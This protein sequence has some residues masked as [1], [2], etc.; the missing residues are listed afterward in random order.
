VLVID[1]DQDFQASVRALLESQGYTVIAAE[2]GK[3]GLQMLVEHNPD[4]IILDIMMETSDEGYS[5]THAI[6]YQQGYERCRQVP[7][8]MVSSLEEAPDERFP[9][10]PEVEMIRPDNYL[11]KPLDISRF[12][13]VVRKT[14][15]PEIVA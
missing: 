8:I 5:V 7:I 3:E 9:M 1:D 6:K 12:L 15:A 2:S 4:A 10:A 13:E 11:T 14:V